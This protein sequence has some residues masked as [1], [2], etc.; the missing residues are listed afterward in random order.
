MLMDDATPRI[1]QQDTPEGRLF[2]VRGAWTAADLT[3]RAVWDELTAQLERL[4]SDARHSGKAAAV[5]WQLG[6][7]DKLDYVGAQV[8]WN[9]WGQQWPAQLDVEPS[10]RTLLEN[11]AK[12]TCNPPP[13]K[14]RQPHWV[15]LFILLGSR[16]LRLVD[17]AKGLLRLIGQLLLDII[18]LIRRPQQGPWRDLSGHLYHIGA[19]ALPITAL[20]GFLIGVVL[21]YLIS[22]QLRQF[23]ADAFIVNILG[24]SLIRELGPVLAAILIAGRSGSAITAQIGVMR[25]T[26]ELDAMR[27]MGIARGFRLVMPRA[28]ALAV[29]MPLISVWTTVAALLGGMLAADISMGVTPAYFINSLPAAVDAANLTLATAKSVVFGVLIALVGCHFGL[30]V[31]PNTESLGQ[32]TTA[33]VVTSITVVIL[34]DALFAVLFKSIG[35]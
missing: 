16:V 6:Q 2:V 34:V 22:Q 5:Q 30:R 4:R 28:L 26:E 13:P 1:E 35:I 11:V 25:V 18:R 15:E 20:V 17:H 14:A 33:S 19:T 24:I 23:G 27:V 32:G 3:T 8:L 7:I 31:K 12:F 21:A 9:H 29:V 10:Q